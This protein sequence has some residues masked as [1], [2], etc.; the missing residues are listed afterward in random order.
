MLDINRV[1]IVGAGTMGSALAQK[2][3]QE[4]ID[5]VMVDTEDRLLKGGL[6]RIRDTLAGGVK[7]GLFSEK[8][9]RDIVN[10]VRPTVKI[11][12]VASCQLV[13]EAV[14]EDFDLKKEVLARVGETVSLDAVVATNT[15][16]FSVSSLARSVS[17]PER[18]LGLH[19]FYHAAKNRLVEVV[20]GKA[21]DDSVFRKTLW[22][23]RRC[24]KDPIV[25]RDSP[26]FV[27]NR[28]FVPWLNEATRIYEE[29]VAGTGL[30]D[31]VASETFECGM[32]PFALMNA[33]G[34]SIA[35]QASRTLGE[36]FGNFY[37]PAGVLEKQA[38]KGKPWPMENGQDPGG[39]IENLVAHRMV[40]AVFFACGQLMD[41]KVC[42]ARDLN[43]GARIGL[44]WRRGPV[45]LYESCG[46]PS[47]R[48][49]VENM[50]G[51]WDLPAPTSLSL[52][53][54]KQQFISWEIKHGTGI[55]FINRPEDL[56]ALNP[57]VV[58]QLSEAFTQL[59]GDDRVHTVVITGCGKAFM[60]GADI[61]FFLDRIRSQDIPGIVAF[62]RKVQAL[63]Q[64][65]DQSRK[66]VVAAVN[67]FA[68]G[69]GLELAMT[70]DILVALPTATFAFPET[71]LAIYPGLG[72]TQ[73]T[74]QRIGP[75]LTKFLIFTGEV[76]PATEA[77]EIGLI[78]G[79]IH[80]NDLAGLLEGKAAVKKK[81]VQRGEKWKEIE[82]FF[83]DHSVS[84]LLG[85]EFAS[86]KWEPIVKQVRSR[87]P[88]ALEIAELLIDEQAGP[89]SE[90]EHLEEIFSTPEALNG[91]ERVAGDVGT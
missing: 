21:T 1:G 16:S 39:R 14:F 20:S 77:L 31:R 22:F 23:M 34:V 55:L 26:G 30:I 40:G 49:L 33:T 13:I 42:T 81:G 43:Q 9:T 79:I 50:T 85:E 10:R 46:E 51:A 36:A 63:F 74:V 88:R 69:G 37:A 56:N 45:E 65:I 15:S 17:H 78:D 35:Y 84:R 54:W 76:L 61:R 64:Q 4:G 8:Q 24:G 86:E 53:D 59:E 2:F 47:V 80:W 90:L 72:G 57:K 18:F 44:R 29:G 73:R 68:L 87:A 52:D 3:A 27:V 58:D 5:V 75:G 11:K 25:C 67:G 32:G 62:T 12:D 71:G 91:L 7:R 66:T 48:R 38:Q 41:E 28:F 19:F 6:K 89:S 70:A 82:A 83:H 60:A